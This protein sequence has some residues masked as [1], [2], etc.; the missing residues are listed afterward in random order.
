MGRAARTKNEV[1]RLIAL[2]KTEQDL[3]ADY[4]LKKLGFIYSSLIH[5]IARKAIQFALTRKRA[6]FEEFLRRGGE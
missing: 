5:E 4:C 6:E 1:P 2:T 3:L